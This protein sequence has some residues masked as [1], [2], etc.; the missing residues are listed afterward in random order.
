MQF[1][2]KAE[3]PKSSRVAQSSWDFCLT[4]QNRNII[5]VESH[6]NLAGQ[7]LQMENERLD[8]GAPALKAQVV[9]LQ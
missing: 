8:L 6:V 2:F 1:S 4:R 7:K 5:L 9:N 3:V